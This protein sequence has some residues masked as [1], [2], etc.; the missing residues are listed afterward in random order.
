MLVERWLERTPGLEP[1]PDGFDF[2]PK[3]REAV[4]T[5]LQEEFV[6]PYENCPDGKLKEQKLAE[7]QKWS[8]SFANTLNEEKY[9]DLLRSGDHRF[10]YR[11][12]LGAMMIAL[13]R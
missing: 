10:S 9:Q 1:E 12:F 13:Y 4:R 2:L 5:Y 7:Y 6:K 11:A 3:Y 8:D